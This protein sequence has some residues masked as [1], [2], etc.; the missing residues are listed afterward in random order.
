MNDTRQ[1]QLIISGGH[2]GLARA[3]NARFAAGGWDVRAPGRDELDVTDANAVSSFFSHHHPDLLICGAGVI[4]DAPIARLDPADWQHVINVNFHG[5]RRCA[6]AVLSEMRN[7]GCGHIIFVSSHS[8][9]HPA[10]GQAA[11][12][13][14]KAALLGITRDLAIEAGSYGV[15]VNAILPGFLET[16]MTSTVSGI[17]RKTV[18][19]DHALGRFNTVEAVASFIWHL[20]QELPHTSGQTFQLDSRTS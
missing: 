17:R 13:T 7:R 16:P 19:S 3:I 14:A 2:G 12:A 15:R 11:Y 6:A 1:R 8:A 9:L 20:H 5:A 18:R 4:R 10:V